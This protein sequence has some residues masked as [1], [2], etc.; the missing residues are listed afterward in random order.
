MRI[1]RQHSLGRSEAKVRVEKLAETLQ[2][3]FDL[4][5]HWEGDRLKVSGSGVNGELAV[6]EHS[7]NLDIQ[8]GLALRFMEPSIRSAVEQ[9]M[10][11]QLA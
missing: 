7:V 9:E 5:S 8:L 6:S 1:E 11:K 4:T 3:Q 10:D 2:R